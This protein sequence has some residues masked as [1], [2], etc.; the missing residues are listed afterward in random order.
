MGKY[1]VL[2]TFLLKNIVSSTY[3]QFLQIL[4][5]YCQDWCHLITIDRFSLLREVNCSNNSNTND[6]D[7]HGDS[8]RI[9]HVTVNY[10]F[11]K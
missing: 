1:P 4:V 3:F 11:F 8:V 9:F 6:T 5:V 7:L 2:I 10:I